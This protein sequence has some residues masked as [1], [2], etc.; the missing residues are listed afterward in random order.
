MLIHSLGQGYGVAPS[1]ESVFPW[2]SQDV[3]LIQPT[4]KMQPK[5]V[6]Y[7]P[8]PAKFMV[9]NKMA[10]DLQIANVVSLIQEK[11]LLLPRLYFYYPRMAKSKGN[12]GLKI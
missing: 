5:D 1:I 3:S 2:R 4:W 11:V 7:N 8:S 12:S 10:L 6:V 9:K